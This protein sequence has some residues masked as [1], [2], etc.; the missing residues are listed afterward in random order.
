MKTIVA[1]VDLSELAFEVLQQAARFAKAFNS[2]VVILHVV[3]REPVVP[4]MSP[5][6]PV[7]M[8]KPSQESLDSHYARL[9]NM[10]DVLVRSG[11]HSSVRQLAGAAAEEVLAETRSLQP[12]LIIVG[13]HPHGTIYHLLIG[14]LVDDVLK[15]APCPVV[16]VPELAPAHAP[17]AT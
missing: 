1:L 17:A 13:A 14:T 10:R 2:E 5:L 9:I 8:R 3:P 7:S 4:D 6:Y 15:N 11:V 12:E 16:V